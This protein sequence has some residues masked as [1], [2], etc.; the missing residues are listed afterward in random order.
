[1]GEDYNPEQRLSEYL[2]VDRFFEDAQRT[3]SVSRD[4]RKEIRDEENRP[5]TTRDTVHG[6]SMDGLF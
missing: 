5:L 3:V 1:M 2:D 6:S 4:V